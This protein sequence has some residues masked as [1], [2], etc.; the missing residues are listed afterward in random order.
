LTAVNRDP[1]YLQVAHVIR[2]RIDSGELA[3]GEAAPTTREIVE[4]FGLAMG[5]AAKTHKW[6]QDNNFTRVVPGRGT[7]VDTSKRYRSAADRVASMVKQGKIYP[8]GNWAKIVS[9]ELVKH[10]PERVVEALEIDSGSS[11]IR[12][13]RITYSAENFPLSAS[14]SW[15][16]GA[17]AE[18]APLLLVCDRIVKGTAAYVASQTNRQ[19]SSRSKSLH[20]ADAAAENDAEHLQV[21][22]DSPVLRGVNWMFATDGTILEYGESVAGPGPNVRLEININQED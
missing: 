10:A 13:E 18:T 16:D 3:E 9:A 8:P 17:L 20:W 4:E 15:F 1:L 2:D 22:L 14:V 12:R 7:V 21:P 6:L 19:L 11:A 5:T